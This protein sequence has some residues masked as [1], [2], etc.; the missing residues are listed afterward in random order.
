[1]K[2]VRIYL[3]PC[4]SKAWA[5]LIYKSMLSTEALAQALVPSHVMGQAVTPHPLALE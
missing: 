1:M 2:R 4:L 3:H 5:H